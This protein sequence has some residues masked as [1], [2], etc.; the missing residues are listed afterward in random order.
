MT[1]MTTALAIIV[2]LAFTTSDLAFA[3]RGHGPG[4]G[5]G[6]RAPRGERLYDVNTIQTIQGQVTNVDTWSGPRSRYQGVHLMV[7]T[8]NETLSVHLGPDW[9]VKDQPIQIKT[10]DQVTITGS[11]ITYGGKS[12]LVAAE[13][14]RGGETLKLRDNTGRPR[15]AGQGGGRRA[16]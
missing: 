12:A 3:G 15:W 4:D 11:R 9:F 5:T 2:A 7:K 14:T 13:V 8:E 6:R 10:G 1:R 16:D